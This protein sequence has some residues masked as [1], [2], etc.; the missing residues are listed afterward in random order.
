MI[1][2]SR[3]RSGFASK[4]TRRKK[5]GLRYFLF[6]G[7]LL[8]AR[9]ESTSESND[10]T[11]S[12]SSAA[13]ATAP[14]SD[15]NQTW[16]FHFQAT[17]ITQ[18]HDVFSAPYAGE[19]SLQREEPWRTTETMTLFL[20]VR[21][22]SGGEFYIDPEASGGRG[23][24]GATGLAGFPNGEA[25]RVGNPQL[26]PYLARLFFRQTFALSEESEPVEADLN[27]IAGKRAHSNVIVTFGKLAAGDVFDDNTYSH[28]PRTQ[29]E[30][31]SLMANGAWD[32]PADT[33]GYTFGG[34]IELNEPNWSVRVGSFAEPTEANG[35]RFDHHLPRA[36]A[37]ALEIEKR[38][39]FHG[40][41]GALRG[42]LFANS[43]RMGKYSDA[44]ALSPTAPDVTATRAY[45]IKYGAGVN[46][47]QGLTR[48]LSV[49]GRASWND[50]HSE[51]W[52]FTEID[53]SVSAGLSLVGTSWHRHDD[54][55]GVAVVSN[56]LSDDHRGYL[57]AG[58]YGFIV[59]DGRLNYARE[60]LIESYY[61]WAVIH[62]LTLSFDAQFFQHPAYNR[63]RGP[64]ELAGV[65]VHVQW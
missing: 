58:G 29:F 55:I 40:H 19:N 21:L 35:A 23:L 17:T 53:S 8:S 27:Q 30:N 60:N 14:V 16:S 62:G 38:F 3:K 41:A 57:A 36:L 61:S 45:R 34:T 48:D 65:R 56:G 37:H 5:I 7:A 47:E 52:M 44:I 43:A 1:R 6:F 20:G 9:A 4:S 46:F 64:V 42:L 31:W 28:D 15:E 26:T 59:G 12:N 39:S 32:Y 24:S 18:A 51:T 54:G 10:H 13:A 33:R 63:D 25:T 2:T 49:F 50:G 11:V 22:W